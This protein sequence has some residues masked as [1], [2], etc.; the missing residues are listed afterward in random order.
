[1]YF[2]TFQESVRIPGFP[3]LISRA[4]LPNALVP[5]GTTGPMF[6]SILGTHLCH[7]GHTESHQLSMAEEK[8]PVCSQKY[9]QNNFKM[10]FRFPG[11]NV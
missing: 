3:K 6:W 10:Y 11:C 2:V 5:R 4:F 8:L 7:L 9:H 1:M